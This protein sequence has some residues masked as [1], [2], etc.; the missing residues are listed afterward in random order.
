MSIEKSIP[1]GLDVMKRLGILDRV[2]SRLVN[3]KPL[4]PR[5]S[6]SHWAKLIK[7]RRI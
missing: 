6:G 5:S 3:D 4:L 1:L 2:I 7:V